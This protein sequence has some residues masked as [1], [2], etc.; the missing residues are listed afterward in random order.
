MKKMNR[1]RILYSLLL[2]LLLSCNASDKASDY[3][4]VD[5]AH[6]PRVSP[7]A[8][9]LQTDTAKDRDGAVNN[10]SRDSIPPGSTDTTKLNIQ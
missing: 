6:G 8:A 2:A 3:E 1:N 9:R 4:R 10:S 7:Q 5:S